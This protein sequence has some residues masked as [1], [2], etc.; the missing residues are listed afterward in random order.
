[1]TLTDEGRVGATTVVSYRGTLEF[2]SNGLL[3]CF[4][5]DGETAR[6]RR[7]RQHPTSLPGLDTHQAP[8]IAIG[9]FSPCTTEETA[10]IVKQHTLFVVVDDSRKERVEDGFCN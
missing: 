6:R 8:A 9:H 3:P 4:H 2:P 5:D 1:M 10:V 7:F